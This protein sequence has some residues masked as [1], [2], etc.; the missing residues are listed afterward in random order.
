MEHLEVLRDLAKEYSVRSPQKLKQ[1]AGK[2]GANYTLK[3]CQKAL[4]TSVPSQT[5]GP[6]PRSQGKSAAEGPGSRLQAD[7]MDFSQNTHGHE[8]DQHRYALQVSDV[9]TR[10]AYTEPLKGKTAIQ[11]DSAMRKIR[12]EIPG[13]FDNAVVTTDKGGEFAGLDKVLPQDAVH[14]Y[15]EGVND[16]AVVDRTMQ[17]LKKDLEDKAQT[18][19][20]GWA[21]NLEEVTK[22]YNFRPNSTVHGSPEDAGKENPQTFMIMQDQAANFQHNRHL[23]LRR[24]GAVQRACAYREPID[25][26]GRSFKPSYGDV[27]QFRRFMEGGNVQDKKGNVAPLKT[28]RAV[29]SGSGEALAHITFQK[30]RT[31][32]VGERRPEPDVREPVREPRV[33]E[34]GS[35]GSGHQPYD[36]FTDAQL[37]MQDPISR[38]I[39][40]HKPK[41][42]AAEK[43]AAA[44]KKAAEATKKKD[45]AAEKK[46]EQIAKWAAKEQAKH[47]REANRIIKKNQ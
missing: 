13:H 31:P 36:R 39:M 1:L 3:E 26:G 19:G 41:V 40:D 12:D 6:P 10:E 5:L 33:Q 20:Q 27:H 34:G 46:K 38:A 29:H 17:T 24:Q 30:R 25:N 14:R 7:L 11:V 37:R 9:F 47:L 22:N 21:N 2:I 16:I 32:A 42:P 43:A 4:E 8:N 44:A 15:K 28:V 23:T 35:S 45:A 18:G